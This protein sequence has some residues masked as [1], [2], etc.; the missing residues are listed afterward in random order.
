MALI[1]A[2]LLLIALAGAA[3][4][5]P[6]RDLSGQIRALFDG[7]GLVSPDMARFLGVEAARAGVRHIRQMRPEEVPR[8]T[9]PAQTNCGAAVFAPR[10]V[11]LD[12]TRARCRNLNHLLHEIAHIAV[13]NAPCRGH[14]DRFYTYNYA[15]AWRLEQTFPAAKTWHPRP[16]GYVLRRAR[17]YRSGAW[18]C[19]GGK[20]FPP[21]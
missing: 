4:A 15:L 8:K 5:S 14:G 11:L 21:R 20:P 3:Q 10:L 7:T 12:L 16:T 19:P 1:R 17:E 2:A 13:M 18:L 9:H 6:A